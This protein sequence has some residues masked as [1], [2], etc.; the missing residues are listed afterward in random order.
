MY[1]AVSGWILENKEILKIIY[2]IVIS[3][4]CLTIVLKAHRIYH[5][6]YYGGLRYFR[7]AFLFLGLAFAIRYIIGGILIYGLISEN[8]ADLIKILFEYF[9]ILGGFLLLYSLL[10]KRLEGSGKGSYSS[11]AN[12]RVLIFYIM[13]FCIALLDFVWNTYYF[14]FVSQ[15][16]IFVIAIALSFIRFRENP[17]RKFLKFYVIAMVLALMA[18]LLNAFAALFFDWK[19]SVLIYVYGLNVIIFIVFLIGVLIIT[20]KSRKYGK[21]KRKA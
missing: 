16:I 7:N 11:L 9:L 20:Q 1:L 2:G 19:K 10:W 13:A 15:A 5:L 18:W 17:K 21:E 8:Y 3:L 14:M 12:I 6:S 4:I